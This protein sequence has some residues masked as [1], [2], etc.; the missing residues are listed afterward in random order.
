MASEPGPLLPGPGYPDNILGTGYSM[1]L[2]G[3]YAKAAGRA[4]GR[5]NLG[6]RA[7]MRRAFQEV[8]MVLPGGLQSS[9]VSAQ[10]AAAGYVTDP[11]LELLQS[12]ATA[13]QH[14]AQAG[15]AVLAQLLQ[16]LG[17]ALCSM[18]AGTVCNNPLCKSLTPELSEQQL[19]V[20]SSRRCSGCRVARYCSKGC[21]VAHWKQ[22]KPACKAA[23]AAA[24][25]AKTAS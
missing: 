24:A 21:Q 12:A 5:R 23:A 19:V 18:P 13:Q 16:G 2:Q 25:A 6:D 3:L 8:S 17:L 1:V 7:D 22:H 15:P 10:L 14:A 11:I 20:G 9:S 4:A